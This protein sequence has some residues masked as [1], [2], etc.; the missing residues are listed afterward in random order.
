MKYENRNTYRRGDIWLGNTGQKYGRRPYLI[1]SNDRFNRTSDYVIVCP[2]TSKKK[3]DL[4]SHVI[5]DT[6][7]S[8]ALFYR[9]TT[10]LVE[11]IRTVS[12]D[13]LYEYMMT[14]SVDE[15]RS[16]NMAIVYTIGGS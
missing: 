9:Q 3:K 11:Q 16:L 1:V 8:S 2:V 6:E 5:V 7:L 15:V 14:L 10:V 12:K 13:C 4:E